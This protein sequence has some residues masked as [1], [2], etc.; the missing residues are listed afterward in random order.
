MKR[1]ILLLLCL[2]QGL[3]NIKASEP[4]AIVISAPDTTFLALRQ[5]HDQAVARQ[6]MQ[7]AGKCLQEMGKICY[8]LGHY[9][10]SLD[11]Y[12]QAMQAFEAAGNK[13][14]QAGL[15]NDIGELYYRNINKTA[16]KKQF[17]KALQLFQTMKNIPGMAETYGHIGHYYEKQQQYDS[18]HYFQHSALALY[19]QLK[20]TVGIARIYEHLGTI[21][22]DL[23]QYDTALSY[24]NKALALYEQRGNKPE[25]LE[26]TNN[27]GD[28]LR[29]TGSYAAG[30][31]WSLRALNLALQSNN[32]YQE[33][34]ACKDLAKAYNLL[35]KN[36]SAFYYME[37]SRKCLSEIYSAQ[38]N[39]QMSFLQ[40]LYD[41]NK[42]SEEINRLENS[43][44]VN[45]VIYIAIGIV[46]ALLV[47]LALAII[48]RQK[49]KISQAQALSEQNAAI[50]KVQ[51]DQ[52][53][54]KSRQ[55]A[56]HTL[57]IIQ[58]NQFLEELR[59]SL[60]QLVQDE[61]RDQKKQLQ[62]LVV[63]INQ[64][65]SHEKQW[66]EFTDVF[67]QVHQVFF[68]KLNAR[69]GDLTNN[70]IR[71]LALHKMNIDSKDMA[72]ILG[73]SP[74]SLRVARYRLRKKLN[75]QEGD[76]LTTFVQNL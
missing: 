51:K 68:D 15:L 12:Q 18:A 54:L 42:K 69:F 36:D 49:L 72:T 61:K 40:V 2:I 58:R 24:F 59:H 27:I 16:A 43:H 30:I 57:D 22:E 9:A 55:L 4:V 60:T 8:T 56:N 47:A 67:E 44:R 50:N 38:N 21:H 11:Y 31:S 1:V 66:K 5:A 32:K 65:V 28:I 63:K 13:K 76:T 71:L 26:V 25:G 33:G 48:S 14:E 41:T 3:T 37:W 64:N 10:S 45:R 52:L 73:I 39:Q 53:E 74:D 17:D 29:K 46:V 23:S 6:D 75:I 19:Q 7:T 34:A 62:Q 20:D 70:D 35:G